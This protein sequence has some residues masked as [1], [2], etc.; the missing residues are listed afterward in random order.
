MRMQPMEDVELNNYIE[1]VSNQYKQV[2]EYNERIFNKNKNRFTIVKYTVNE[3]DVTI[4]KA[5]EEMHTL[6]KT[7][8]TQEEENIIT[9]FYTRYALIN[10]TLIE[11]TFRVDEKVKHKLI[12]CGFNASLI[13]RFS[14][15]NALMSKDQIAQHLVD[16]DG[17]LKLLIKWAKNTDTK[18]DEDFIKE[19]H[20]LVIKT[21]RF[22][23]SKDDTGK[24]VI[25]VKAIRKWR[26][27]TVYFGDFD[28]VLTFF[29]HVPELMMTFIHWMNVIVNEV[30][31]RSKDTTQSRLPHAYCAYLCAAFIHNTFMEIH[32]FSDGN[33]RTGR[34][35]A[36]LPLVIVGFPVISIRSSSKEK[37]LQKIRQSQEEG[38]LSVLA[39]FLAAE[40][41]ASLQESTNMYYSSGA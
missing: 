7:Y 28:V 26:N 33:G 1:T 21:N 13:D 34:I 6:L 18:I 22:E 39:E 20:Y 19:I 9:A 8:E 27:M 5:I 12:K 23:K 41:L 36:S 29:K 14:A 17:A 15:E 37:Y 10:S 3:E 11:D 38:K 30:K 40:S 25:A 16:M 31:N 32:P 24:E 2:L 35:L 4:Y